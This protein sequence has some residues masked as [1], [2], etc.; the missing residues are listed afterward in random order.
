MSAGDDGMVRVWS[1][2]NGSHVRVIGVDDGAGG[3]AGFDEGRDEGRGSVRA[4]AIVGDK[5]ITGG[6]DEMVKVYQ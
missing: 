3:G 5:L 2:S 4:V 1:T 6:T